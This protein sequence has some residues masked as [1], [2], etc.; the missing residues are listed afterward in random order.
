MM[1]AR[2]RRTVHASAHTMLTVPAGYD[3]ALCGELVP[4]HRVRE[5]GVT[6]GPCLDVAAKTLESAAEISGAGRGVAQRAVARA[7]RRAGR[8]GGGR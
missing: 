2:T 7:R 8:R 4:V 3:R 1:A 5:T 6:C